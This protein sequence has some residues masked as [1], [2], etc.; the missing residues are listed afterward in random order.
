MFLYALLQEPSDSNVSSLFFPPKNYSLIL[1]L[2]SHTILRFSRWRRLPGHTM[3][4]AYI[5]RLGQARCNHTFNLLPACLPAC[6]KKKNSPPL[7]H[8]QHRFSSHGSTSLRSHGER[9][10]PARLRWP[11]GPWWSGVSPRW[12]SRRA[13]ECKQDTGEWRDRRNGGMEEDGWRD[14]NVESAASPPSHGEEESL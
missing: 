1:F 12:H 6:V 13:A 11:P 14:E 7:S 2:F 4:K 10:R 5:L 3:Q 9:W 8:H